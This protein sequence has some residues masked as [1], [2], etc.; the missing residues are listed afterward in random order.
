M[1]EIIKDWLSER[2]K[3]RE[4]KNIEFSREF[5]RKNL[6]ILWSVENKVDEI[7]FWRRLHLPTLHEELQKARNCKDVNA[8]IQNKVNWLLPKEQ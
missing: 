7:L 8:Y 2:K 5:L 3:Q 1:F 6:T 4:E